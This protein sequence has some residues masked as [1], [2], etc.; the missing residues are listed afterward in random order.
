MQFCVLYHARQDLVKN[1]STFIFTVNILIKI[2]P[3]FHLNYIFSA[4]R[5]LWSGER[6]H[7][8]DS[9]NCDAQVHLWPKL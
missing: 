3:V 4:L 9:T 6:L 7:N 5:F 8:R 1:N 2:I